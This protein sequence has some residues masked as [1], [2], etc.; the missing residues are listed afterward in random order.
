ME[1]LAFQYP[2]WFILLCI[3]AGVVYAGGLYYR[4]TTFQYA[5]ART[6]RWLV[7]LTALRFVGVTALCFLL[8][9]PFLR[10]RTTESE[11]PIILVVQDESLS[12]RYQQTAEDSAA[13]A[14]TLAEATA[15]LGESYR[16][17]TYRFGE[18]LA[19]GLPV[20]FAAKVTDM[21][22]AFNGLYDRY[23]N[24]NVGAIIVVSDG[25]YNQGN[26]PLYG[27]SQLDAPVYTIALGD[28]VQPKD[29][30]LSQVRHNSIA[31]LDDKLEVQLGI[32]AYNLAGQNSQLTLTHITPEG[33][34]IAH[35]EVLRLDANEE[36]IEKSIFLDMEATG[37]QQYAVQ[38]SP[39]EGEAST[40]NNR[41]RIFIEV[42]DSR[43]QLLMLAH[44]PHPDLTALRAA[45]EKNR[46]YEVTLRYAKEGVAQPEQ[47]D[48]AILHQLPVKNSDIALIQQLQEA[49]L[50]LWYILGAQT[51]LNAFQQVQDMVR[52][53]NA[54]GSLNEVQAA[55]QSRFNLF[56]V[57]EEW[58]QQVRKYPPLQAPFGDYA[59]A[60]DAVNLL[61]Q[62]IGAVQTDYPLLTFRQ[63]VDERQAVW[64]GTGIWRWRLY[65]YLQHNNHET[66]DN[67]LRKMV[68]YLA[69]KAD[70]RAFRVSLPKNIFDENEPVRL[71]AE[72]YNAAYELINTPDVQLEIANSEGEV[73]PF[74]FNRS[75]E[76]YTLEA[77]YFPVG[78]YTYTATTTFNGEA[79]T[80]NG[81]FSVQPVNL[82]ARQTTAN[83][84]L[85]Y[86]LA[87]QTGGALLF[88]S[89]VDQ[90]ADNIRN[91]ED[92]R[93]VLR[94]T[95][96]TQA[97]INLKWIFFVLV[98][99]FGL[100]WFI[101]RFNGAY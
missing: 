64:I 20:Q 1:Q 65:H 77:G 8:L 52:I 60:T 68:Q 83:H 93:P 34:T 13:L 6:Q 61:T 55:V 23:V 92:V 4:A 63:T 72:L 90:L 89:Q 76:A 3:L 14:A 100:E 31:Y 62:Q 33:N 15:S 25:V 7:G 81:Q 19:E 85:L 10:T 78:N 44:A 37:V 95:Y 57:P 88:P 75:G 26:H 11:E 101:R 97:I 16:V 94:D 51:Q 43:Q 79:F 28:T 21:G 48:L 17:E 30:Q 24:Q 67:F 58:P 41:Q 49:D 29:L 2:T 39:I 53:N 73:Y 12:I 46:N 80:T 59:T 47:Y 84:Q 22:Q 54:N 9:S 98:G 66:I 35:Q 50:P 87:Q 42:L 38:L 27:A 69:V 82:E 32:A 56:K 86:Q 71:E 40:L 74:T 18:S 96:T 45:L 91:R 70:K 99:L 5:S 36:W